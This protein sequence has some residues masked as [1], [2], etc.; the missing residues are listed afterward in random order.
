MDAP[1]N[2]PV[3]EGWFT[4]DRNAPHLL[5]VRCG[6]C[7]TYYFPTA[8]KFCRHPDCAGE[9]FEQVK[10]SRTGRVWSYTNAVYKPPEPYVASEPFVPY[11]IAAVELEKERMIVL[12]QVASGVGVEA[13][14]VGMEV[15]LV[16]EPLDDGKLS[17]KWKPLPEGVAAR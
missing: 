5:G 15:E 8:I 4:L 7:G 3:L 14:R 10:L 13:L 16:L 6:A 1:L 17:W 9:S 2:T 12:G 11:A